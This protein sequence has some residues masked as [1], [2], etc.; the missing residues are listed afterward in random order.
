MALVLVNMEKV[1]AAIEIGD[2]KISSPSELAEAF[3]YHFAKIGHEL[4]RDI[5]P[6]NTLIARKATTLLN[7]VSPMKSENYLK[8]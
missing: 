6:A 5:P 2:I 7:V 3:N 4:G 1:I 8:N